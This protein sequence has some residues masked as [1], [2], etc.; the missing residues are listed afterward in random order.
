MGILWTAVGLYVGSYTKLFLIKIERPPWS[1]KIHR[2]FPLVTRLEIKSLM[3]MRLKE[4]FNC[5]PRD[6]LFVIAEFV[7][8]E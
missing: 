1:H 8:M 6:I 7:A 5:L 3:T 4:P 2:Q